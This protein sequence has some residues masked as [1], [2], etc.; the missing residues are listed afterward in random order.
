MTTI[1]SSHAT[2]GHCWDDVVGADERLIVASY[3]GTRELSG[4]P[5]LL[6]ID[7]YRK[8]YG[9][10]PQPLAES[11]RRFP[12]SCGLAGWNALPATID[13]L[14]SARG[15]GVPIVYTSIEPVRGQPGAPTQR[16]D[17]A[18]DPDGLRIIEQ[19]APRSGE[20]ILV[21]P[22]ASAFF[23]TPLDGW[24]R[25]FDVN[26][27]ILAGESTSGCVRATAVDAY[28]LGFTVIVAEDSVFDRSALSHK[29]SLFDINLKYGS[30]VHNDVL[31]D[32]LTA[33]A[34]G[35]SASR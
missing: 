17:D 34:P 27:L 24:L 15:A 10:R 11:T 14:A 16:T 29:V 33:T 21:K 32:F 35:V 28:S 2:A 13:L 6:M 30:V 8:A 3:P 18:G 22:R 5:A 9:D 7:V 26:T 4:R 20:P 31:V 1:R 25:R 23:G 19:L 12:S